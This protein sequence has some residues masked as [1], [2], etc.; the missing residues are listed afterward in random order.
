[1][2]RSAGRL[3]LLIIWSTEQDLLSVHVSAEN[4]ANI[5]TER[6]TQ[7]SD[8]ASVVAMS[9]AVFDQKYATSPAVY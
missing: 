3:F 6:R 9:R 8:S 7:E 2:T 5:R 1:M 4:R